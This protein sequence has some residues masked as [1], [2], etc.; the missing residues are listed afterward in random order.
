MPIPTISTRSL[1]R[2]RW[3]AIYLAMIGWAILWGFPWKFQ[4]PAHWPTDASFTPLAHAFFAQGRPWGTHT[5]HTSGIWGFLRFTFYNP[6]TFSL[7]V[8]ANVA[9]AALIGWYFADRSYHLPRRRWVLLLA[10]AALL[11]LLSASDDARWYMPIFGLLVLRTLDRTRLR[12][13][14][15]LAVQGGVRPPG[16]DPHYALAHRDTL[17]GG[18]RNRGSDLLLAVRHDPAL[19]G[20]ERRRPG[21]RIAGA[22]PL[23]TVGRMGSWDP[24]P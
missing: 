8:C 20:D 16:R 3:P 6:E 7:F 5:L 11:P 12:D 15:L 21:S 17:G 24:G 14:P 18:H 4:T 10:S 13:A 2:A 9:L 19:A 1:A 22:V 23:A